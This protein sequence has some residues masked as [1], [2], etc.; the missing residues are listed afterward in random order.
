LS[1]KF[2]SLNESFEAI[3]GYGKRIIYKQFEHWIKAS[4]ALTGFDLTD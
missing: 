4:R 1:R 3:S 2:L